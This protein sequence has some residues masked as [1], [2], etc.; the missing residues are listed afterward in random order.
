M[1]PQVKGAHFGL[2]VHGLPP[3]AL[4]Q[5]EPVCAKVSYRALVGNVSNWPGQRPSRD[6]RIATDAV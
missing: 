2:A 4:F 3:L 5:D 1:L 6:H